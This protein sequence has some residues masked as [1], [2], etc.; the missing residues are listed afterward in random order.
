MQIIGY[1]DS[2]DVHGGPFWS[3]ERLSVERARWVAYQL[4]FTAMKDALV[5]VLGR[6]ESDP[7][8]GFS[9][10]LL[11]R[12]RRVE[13]RFVRR[14][15]AP[16]AATSQPVAESPRGPSADVVQDAGPSTPPV[17]LPLAPARRPEPAVSE[18]NAVAVPALRSASE[19]VADARNTLTSGPA[20][21]VFA[22][23]DGA[24]LASDRVFVGVRGEPGAA[25]ELFDGATL[26]APAHMRGD[27][28]VDFI[29]VPLARGPHRLRVRM[30]NSWGQERWDS[31]DVHV[32]GRPARFA[33]EYAPVVLVAGGQPTDTLRVRVLDQWNVPVVG[34]AFVTALA[35]GAAIVSADQ[36]HSSVGVQVKADSSGWLTI[37]LSGGRDVR[38]G[39]LALRAGD[40][41]GEVP[42]QILPAMRPLMMTAVGRIGVGASPDAFGAATARG[43]LDYRTSV[44]VSVDSRQLDAGRE[45]FGRA[46]DP[47]SEAQY[48]ILG[49]ASSAHTRSASRYAVA[50]RLERGM[51]WLAFGDLSTGS[52]ASGL[53][54]S[55]YDRALAGVA[56]HIT[57]GAVVWQGFGATSSER[58]AQMQI[59]GRG[60]SGPY[61]IGRQ[62]RPGTERV[63]IETRALE[64]AQRYLARQEMVRYVDYQIDYENGLLLFKQPVPAMDLS[65][66]P[67]FIVVTYG[68]DDGGAPSTVWGLR[69]SADARGLRTRYQLDSV[70]IGSTFIRDGRPGADRELA[71]VDF[72]FIKAG[73][74]SLRAELARSATPDSVGLAASI[75][76]SVTFANGLVSLSA[77]WLHS[78]P[79]FHNPAN[80][81][82]TGGAADLRLGARFAQGGTEFRLDHSAQRFD[83]QSTNRSRSIASFAQQFGGAWRAEARVA[84]DHFATGTTPEATSQASELKLTWTPLSKLSVWAEGRR[85]FGG[86]D[87]V[88]AVQPDYV[89]GGARLRVSPG[90]SFELNHRHV[91][92]P[93]GAGYSVTTIGG[94]SELGFGTEAWGSYEIAGAGAAHGA[95][96]VGLNNRLRLSTAWTV[97]AMF[98]RRVGLSRAPAADPLRALPFLQVEEDY[99][100]A[101]LG[102]EWLPAGKPYRA[103]LRGE[104]RDGTERSSRLV[105]LAGE[106]SLSPA[107][108]V[109]TRQELIAQDD[110]LATG[111]SDH[112]RFSWLTGLAFRPVWSDELNFLAK[113]E[114]IDA[115]NPLGGG[116]LT[117]QTGHESRRILT[118][119][120]IWSPRSALELATRYAVRYTDATVT[121]TDGVVQ[122]LGSSAEYAG[123]SLDIRMAP[124]VGLRGEGRLLHEGTSASTRWDAAPQ[125][126]LI[127]MRGIEV[128]GGYRAG[129]L[130]DPDFAVRGGPG[131][132]VTLGAA[133]T[134]QS[135]H[136]VAGYWRERWSR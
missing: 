106:A 93:N 79:E 17:P 62:L 78:D 104:L 27:G 55:G 136:N 10:D 15:D 90:A 94:R 91:L 21:T 58:L 71:G 73:F 40:A 24:V 5:E 2:N 22:P 31:L 100:S 11:R 109:L 121:H 57:T 47:L 43:R 7:L 51:D 74:G 8:A 29:A 44:V 88:S 120:A 50:A 105:T 60:M 124:W 59:R 16:F 63:V 12:N 87:A 69:A 99:W 119:E 95:A 49:D 86:S 134:E 101:A 3:N 82:L 84:A 125:L 4:H 83:V 131:W 117:M 114:L 123:A 81:A 108:A 38:V 20:V 46:V 34:G 26:I 133:I 9:D 65:G 92:I 135:I 41:V 126:V 68:A 132:F 102:S 129:D 67:V 19:R 76:G 33:S 52:F 66:N 53:A 28:V 30:K 130:R 13:L 103:S 113:V 36:D 127:P 56:G 1:T 42:L 80:V 54:L 97:N 111:V 61:D 112:R 115:N 14:G 122:P 45:E 85:H 18:R 110:H 96:L 25:V 77:G 98:E 70:R 89:G 72:G 32:S 75:E 48:P 64:N 118:A 6:G 23:A 116:V 39:S 35:N 128:A 107:F 37:E